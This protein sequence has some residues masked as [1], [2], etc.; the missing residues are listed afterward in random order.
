MEN[1]S[2]ENEIGI[3]KNHTPKPFL[4]CFCLPKFPRSGVQQELVG[5]AKLVLEFRAYYGCGEYHR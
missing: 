1:S 4:V 2:T 3:D 5:G